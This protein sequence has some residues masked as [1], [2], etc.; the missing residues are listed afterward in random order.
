M[1]FNEKYKDNI[2]L[3]KSFA[4]AIKIVE[5]DEE[6]ETLRKFVLANQLLKSGTSIGAN[7][8]EAQNAESKK[9]FIHKMKI[10]IKEADETEYW[11]FICD[12]IKNYPESKHL[13]SIIKILNKIISSSVKS[14]NNSKA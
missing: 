1:T 10:A 9:D 7:I 8:K 3:I 5:Y 6:L 12:A 13:E 14:I 11:L 4:F 2:I